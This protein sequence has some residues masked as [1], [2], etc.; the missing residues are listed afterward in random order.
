MSNWMLLRMIRYVLKYINKKSLLLIFII[1]VIKTGITMPIALIQG[2]LLDG[3]TMKKDVSFV[4]NTSL[5]LI[6]FV[7]FQVICS[8]IYNIT[9]N[10]FVQVSLFEMRIG[11]F[12]HIYCIPINEYKKFNSNYLLNRIFN[13]TDQLL[14]FGLNIILGAAQNIIILIAG[15]LIIIKIDRTLLWSLCII[16]PYIILYNILKKDLY[17][18]NYALK[19]NTNKLYSIFNES[20]N[21]FESIKKNSWVFF[22]IQKINKNFQL[23][24]NSYQKNIKLST[25][26]SSLNS[27]FSF[28][29]SIMIIIFGTFDILHNKLTIGGLITINITVQFLISPINDFLNYLNNYQLNLVSFNRILEINLIKEEQNG[30]QILDKSIKNISL[31]QVIFSYENKAILNITYQFEKNHIYAITGKS[32]SGKTSLI[33]LLLGIILPD[34]GEIII[35]DINIHNMDKESLRKNISLVE[36]EPRMFNDT[37]YNNLTYGL[38]NKV[39][40]DKLIEICQELDM[41]DMINKL[42]KKL[43]TIIDENSYNISGGEKQRIAICRALLKKSDVII[44]DEPSSALD[45]YTTSELLS[46]LRNLKEDRIILMITHSDY[47]VSFCD[48]ILCLN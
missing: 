5:L 13:D 9:Y 4:I 41:M 38:T 43:E 27:S 24:F 22:E 18:T 48:K 14:A 33:N 25:Y 39:T 44:L 12:Q 31:K 19:Q 46:I 10:K 3:V 28:L 21:M 6:L 37:M 20:F 7:F 26:F 35:N 8:I 29:L 45:E 11:I 47:I 1:L 34:S 40:D 2:Y 17:K 42:P 15:L 32:G 36:Q 23:Y 16:I 30:I